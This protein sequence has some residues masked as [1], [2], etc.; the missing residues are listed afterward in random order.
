[1]ANKK[2]LSAHQVEVQ[3]RMLDYASGLLSASDRR[4]TEAFIAEAFDPLCRV[5]A[6]RWSKHNGVEHENLLG[7]ARMG[8]AKAMLAYDPVKYPNVPFAGIIPTYI[9]SEIRDSVFR[10]KRLGAPLHKYLMKMDADLRKS[11]GLSAGT[12]LDH[13]LTERLLAYRKED[14]SAL[15]RNYDAAGR[16]A[17]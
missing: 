2:R 14:G 17:A 6:G 13:L 1:M 12:T 4:R 9:E 11:T 3:E 7:D 5:I 8:L 10:T 15:V 16:R